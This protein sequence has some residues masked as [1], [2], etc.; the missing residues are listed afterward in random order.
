MI[1]FS[2]PGIFI[3]QDRTDPKLCKVHWFHATSSR[4]STVNHLCH[5]NAMEQGIPKLTGLKVEVYSI[6]FSV[7]GALL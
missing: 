5:G 3:I 2:Y 4:L 1:S 6:G 7:T